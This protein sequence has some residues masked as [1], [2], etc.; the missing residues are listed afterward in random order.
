M[1]P[2]QVLSTA[3]V[4]QRAP[5]TSFK[6]YKRQE[7]ALSRS[8]LLPVTFFYTA[9]SVVMF[10][11]VSRTAHPYVAVGFYITGIPLWTFVEYLTHR[12]VLHGQYKPGK[13]WPRRLVVK[14]INS[15]HWEHHERPFDGEHINGELQDLLPM[16]A[17]TAPLSFIFPAFTAPMLL[18]GVVQAYVLE[19]WV[20][21]S[22]HYYNFGNPYFR[23]IRKHHIYHHTS[24]G[25]KLGYGFTSA[26]WDVVFKT[27]FPES[28]RHRLY[29]RR[30]RANL[31]WRRAKALKIRSQTLQ[32]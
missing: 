24:N 5:V 16:F 1:T 17:V 25:M 30:L 28:V 2:D 3:N 9:Y 4:D 29:G 22:V 13:S 19:E 23:Y 15:L 8:L 20:H 7:A 31:R 12:Y 21:H 6:V 27:R 14:Q 11:L 18:A 26:M 10:M 32:S